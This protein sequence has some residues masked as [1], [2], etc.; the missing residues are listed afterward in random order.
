MKKKKT[1]EKV[2]GYGILLVE[3]RGYKFA[4]PVR[5]K[6]AYHQKKSNYTTRIWEYRGK[7]V[8]HGLDYSKAVI[9]KED[10]YIVEKEFLLE[11]HSD[12][13]K[14]RDNQHHIITKFTAYVERYI[15]AVKEEKQSILSREYRFSTL[16]NY[17]DELCK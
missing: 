15:D 2:R 4:I 3:I 17:H 16:Q 11:V 6:I 8:R 1:K 7:K 12:A 9:I 14:I 10:R 13:V 5:S